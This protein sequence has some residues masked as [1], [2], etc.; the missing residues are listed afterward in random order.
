VTKRIEI[1]DDEYLEVL[2]VLRLIKWRAARAKRIVR[3]GDQ[4]QDAVLLEDMAEGIVRA[5]DRVL[6]V[7]EYNAD[8]RGPCGEVGGCAGGFDAAPR[9]SQGRLIKT[10]GVER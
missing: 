3:A 10:K 6:E 9:D 1:R 7:V 4:Y 2:G 5:V 8:L